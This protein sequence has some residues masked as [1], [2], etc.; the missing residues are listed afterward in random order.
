MTNVRNNIKAYLA[1]GGVASRAAAVYLLR[2]G[3]VHGKHIHILEE[4]RLGGSLDAAGSPDQGYS[5]RGSRR[6]EAAYVLTYELL[7][8]IPSLDEPSKSVTLDMLEFS[9][10]ASLKT[11]QSTRYTTYDAVIRPLVSWLAQSGCPIAPARGSLSRPSRI[12]GSS[13]TF[14]R[15]YRA[16]TA[17]PACC[18]IQRA[19]SCQE[20]RVTGP[21]SYPTGPS[22]SHSSVN[23]AR[24][25]T[26]WSTQSRTRS[27]RRGWPSLLFSASPRRSRR[28]TRGWNTP[29]RWSPR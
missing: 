26:T 27:V 17:Y 19:S 20:Q 11:I 29:T 15:P 9:K 12:L 10:A 14:R 6:Y 25:P 22:I 7:A 8:G 28:H 18:R 24:V 5:M 16:R 13:P 4:S 2:D 1:G 3:Q 21:T 23:I